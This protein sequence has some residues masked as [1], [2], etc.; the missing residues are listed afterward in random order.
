MSVATGFIT[1]WAVIGLGWVLGRIGMLSNANQKTLSNLAFFVGNPCLLFMIVYQAN[2][3]HA[4]SASMTVSALAVVLTALIYIAIAAFAY[5]GG[6]GLAVVGAMLACYTNASN[7]GIPIAGYVLGDMSWMAPILLMQVGVIQPAAITI[8]DVLKARRDGTRASVLRNL[9]LPFRNP[10]TVGVL[11]GLILNLLHVPLPTLITSPVQLV[12]SMSVPMM[13]VA[14]GVSMYHSGMPTLRGHG[15]MWVLTALKLVGQPLL[16]FLLAKYLFVLP[17][18]T[19]RAVA[20]I[21][22]LPSA[23]NIFVIAQYYEQDANLA[24]D[25]IFVDTWL[26]IPTLVAISLLLHV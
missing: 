25:T 5:R 14:F 1:V 18:A 24:R 6:V 9:T 21:A 20:V 15:H 2:L 19:V 17:P 22:G 11:L 12:G 4:F 23:Q 7:L 16:A 8:L 3:S 10:M 26:S 13:L